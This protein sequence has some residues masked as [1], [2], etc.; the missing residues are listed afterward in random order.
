MKGRRPGLDTI[1]KRMAGS[2]SGPVTDCPEWLDQLAKAEWAR[3]VPELELL[4]IAGPIDAALLASYCQTYAN[5]VRC[6]RIVQDEGMMIDGPQGNKVLHPA[7]R[8][9]AKLLMELRKA[10]AEFGFSPASRARVDAPPKKDAEQSDFDDF[11][12]EAP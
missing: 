9:A 4:G 10:A 2:Y 12:R 7:A 6:E 3:I 8:H 11:Q 5:W 1:M